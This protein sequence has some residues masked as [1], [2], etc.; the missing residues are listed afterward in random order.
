MSKDISTMFTKEE[1][2]LNGRKG[3]LYFKHE[4]IS[5]IS[6]REYGMF[7]QNRKKQ[8]KK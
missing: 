8:N 7:L 4:K 3:Y 5:D 2:K 1:N 6:P